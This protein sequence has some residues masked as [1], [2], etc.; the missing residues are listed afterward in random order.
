MGELWGLKAYDRQK[1]THPKHLHPAGRSAETAGTGADD[2]DVALVPAGAGNVKFG[3]HSAVGSETITGYI[4]IKD[5]GG[6]SRKI[7]VIS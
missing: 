2:M 6:T 3:T 7:A 1:R 4:T 5:S